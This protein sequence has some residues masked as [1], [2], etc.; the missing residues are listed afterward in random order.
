MPYIF[1]EELDEGDEAVEVYTPDQYNAIIEERDNLITER[2]T[3]TNSYNQMASERDNLSIQL[4][5]AK[6]KFA[7]AFLSKP[8]PEPP[9]PPDPVKS[10]DKIDSFDTLF[11]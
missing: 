7:D 2:D 11:E 8:K 10:Y 4:V 3:L 5:E 6:T 1:K 9:A